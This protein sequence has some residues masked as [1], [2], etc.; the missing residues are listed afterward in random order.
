M[1]HAPDQQLNAVWL[2]KSLSRFVTA[3][4]KGRGESKSDFLRRA[5]AREAS[6]AVTK[7]EPIDD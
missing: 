2:P 7:S 5:I 4:A 1:A 3:I 6:T